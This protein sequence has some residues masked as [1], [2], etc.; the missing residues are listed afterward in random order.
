MSRTKIAGFVIELK[1]DAI[2]KSSSN[3][4]YNTRSSKSR[5]N[6]INLAIDRGR[7]KTLNLKELIHV[8]SSTAGS[9]VAPDAF[10]MTG[11][12]RAEILEGYLCALSNLD[13]F[14]RSVAGRAREKK[15]GQALAF[16]GH[17]RRSTL[18]NLIRCGRSPGG[19]RWAADRP[20][21]RCI[22]ELQLYRLMVWKSTRFAASTMTAGKIKDCSK[23][24][25]GRARHAIIKKELRTSNKSTLCRA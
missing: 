18:G 24:W 17:G 16:D 22:L 8:T 6:V 13:D 9:G 21:G 1:R 23:S 10:R 14:I 7:P 3:N 15:P 2:P 4:L 19:R 5:S 12:E 25:Q 20:P 11:E